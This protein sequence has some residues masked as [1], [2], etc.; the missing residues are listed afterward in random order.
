M[1]VFGVYP[2]D[3]KVFQ[4]QDTL[5][6]SNTMDSLTAK[7]VERKM[8]LWK[9]FFRRFHTQM[10]KIWIDLFY[11]LLKDLFGGFKIPRRITI[12][13]WVVDKCT[14]SL[15][16]FNFNYIISFSLIWHAHISICI[17][18]SWAIYCDLLGR[19]YFFHF[20]F[21]VSLSLFQ[22]NSIKFTV[23]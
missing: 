1:F 9:I 15:G 4:C 18:W 10:Y 14:V 11:S 22:F 23:L 12:C 13:V 20:I 19:Y 17:D 2:R 3:I 8:N 6:A 5:A 7:I 16:A 21:S